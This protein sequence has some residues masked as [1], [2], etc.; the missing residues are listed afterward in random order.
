[1]LLVEE[2]KGFL[3]YDF[4]AELLRPW[5]Y[6]AL[7][8]ALLASNVA[9]T[10]LKT[11]DSSFPVLFKPFWNVELEAELTHYGDFQWIVNPPNLADTNAVVIIGR[12]R[13][14]FPNCR[15]AL[16]QAARC[17]FE[18]GIF[19]IPPDRSKLQVLK[20]AENGFVGL[21]DRLKLI[22]TAYVLG[23]YGG[24]EIEALAEDLEQPVKDAAR[25][26]VTL[27]ADPT[28]PLHR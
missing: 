10:I 3:A 5:R 23:S 22:S 14:F 18:S 4:Q 2:S 1:M 25:L 17:A 21:A 9:V 13:V 27:W 19:L 20:D 28:A 24:I 11:V 26:A 12:G 7:R 6:S 8:P 16:E 15:E